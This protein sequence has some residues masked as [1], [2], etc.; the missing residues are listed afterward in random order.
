[1]EFSF[2]GQNEQSE[3]YA[4]FPFKSIHDDEIGDDNLNL[5]AVP[6]YGRNP[7]ESG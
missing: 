3:G 2:A 1:M 4:P 5:I 7:N 6:Q